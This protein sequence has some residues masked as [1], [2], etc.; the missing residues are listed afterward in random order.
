M[1]TFEQPQPKRHASSLFHRHHSGTHWSS[2]HTS[3]EH[4]RPTGIFEGTDAVAQNRKVA[5]QR[6][7][8]VHDAL[9]LK[10]HN[11]TPLAE[12]PGS[13]SSTSSSDP[14]AI[15]FS[16][17]PFP[18]AEI[19]SFKY[20]MRLWEPRTAPDPEFDEAIA[21][22]RLAFE[23]AAVKH[24]IRRIALWNESAEVKEKMS[25]SVWRRRERSKSQLSKMWV[26]EKGREGHLFKDQ[27][28]EM[29][30]QEG[31][32]QLLWKL[33]HDPKAPLAPGLLDEC[34]TAVKRMYG[35]KC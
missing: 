21:P 16:E 33:L 1:A 34:T 29:T 22:T 7:I 30:T 14:F 9:E 5:L 17:L 26:S 4:L 15:D 20:F 31:L 13:S 35:M 6:V 18:D 12:R 27:L 10:H 8:E 25:R 23:E 19:R 32:A 3:E 11:E 24:F 28:K 2:R